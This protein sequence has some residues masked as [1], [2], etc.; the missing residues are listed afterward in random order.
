MIERFAIDQYFGSDGFQTG[1][2]G[3]F[4]AH[5]HASG[6]EPVARFAA[7]TVAEVGKELID[8]TWWHTDIGRGETQCGK[9]EAQPGSEIGWLRNGV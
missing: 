2:L 5:R 6:V 9:K 3:D 7:R 4:T 1:I 8:A